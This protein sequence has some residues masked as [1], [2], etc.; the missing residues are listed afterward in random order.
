MTG[1]DYLDLNPNNTITYSRL[2]DSRE[3]IK[4]DDN[5]DISKP[6]F[7]DYSAI[8]PDTVSEDNEEWLRIKGRFHEDG[9][10]SLTRQLSFRKNV[11]SA[12]KSAIVASDMCP[13]EI[14]FMTEFIAPHRKK[15]YDPHPEH[16]PVYR[17]LVPGSQ[18]NRS[19]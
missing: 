5:I 17:K 3:K 9:L 10:L 7:P 12:I 19:D 14:E 2:I 6:I 18:I 8:Y 13:E 15:L 1:E 4:I 16:I 11:K